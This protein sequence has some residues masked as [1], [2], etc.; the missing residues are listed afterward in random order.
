MEIEV[1]VKDLGINPGTHALYVILEDSQGKKLSIWIGL[2]EAQ[3]ISIV[4]EGISVLQPMTHDLIVSVIVGLGGQIKKVVVD[5]LTKDTFHAHIYTEK[6]GEK[7]IFDSRP[8]DAIA[9]A[10]RVGCP[11]FV[12]GKI[13][14]ALEV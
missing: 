1:Q 3:A 6:E 12:E 10:L 8:S 13:L 11:I 5:E 2:A 9:L 7:H 4:L 14:K